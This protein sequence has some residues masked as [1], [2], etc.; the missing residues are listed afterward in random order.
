MG[1]YEAVCIAIQKPTFLWSFRWRRKR[2][3]RFVRL[4]SSR[5]KFHCITKIWLLVLQSITF[6]L[7][8]DLGKLF[9]WPKLLLT[10]KRTVLKV[11]EWL[12]RSLG[13]WFW[14][15]IP[16]VHCKLM[17]YFRIFNCQTSTDRLISSIKVS[18]RTTT[19]WS[20]VALPKFL[21]YKPI[22]LG[23]FCII[24]FVL[25]FIFRVNQFIMSLIFNKTL[26]IFQ[27]NT[28]R[29]YPS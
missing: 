7:A 6:W 10:L 20:L 5:N 16:N 11:D 18:L 3:A 24:W 2:L 15:N 9:L 27:L 19:D 23:L 26:A 22:L 8:F 1:R 14:K 17:P 12:M 28:F 21:R 4:K 13:C 29:L 25:G